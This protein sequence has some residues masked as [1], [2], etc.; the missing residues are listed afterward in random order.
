MWDTS[1]VVILVY[2]NKDYMILYKKN[3]LQ[4]LAIAITS[5][6]PFYMFNVIKN[7]SCCCR[8][9]SKILTVITVSCPL[10]PPPPK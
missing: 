3:G 8:C 1:V 5:T 9:G 7:V 2:L 6:D 4:I 10:P